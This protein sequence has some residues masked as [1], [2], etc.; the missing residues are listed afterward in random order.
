MFRKKRVYD[1]DDGRTV[2]DM[3]G[4]ERTP[5]MV[6][7]LPDKKADAPDSAE[8]PDRPWEQ[9]LTKSE[10]RSFVLG[11]MSASLLIALIFIVVFAIAIA[12]IMLFV[13]R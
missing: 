9:N 5:L 2:A 11:A 7:H 6:P 4:V 12:L 8:Q 13:N 10:R 1:D 3:S